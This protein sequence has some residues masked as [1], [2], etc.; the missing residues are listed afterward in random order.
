MAERKEN[1]NTRAAGSAGQSSAP[2]V[3]YEQKGGFIETR[4]TEG[5]RPYAHA[6]QAAANRP[7]TFGAMRR[8]VVRETLRNKSK[9]GA[10]ALFLL[11][12]F[13]ALCLSNAG[14]FKVIAG[15]A[16]ITAGAAQAGATLGL[17][18][19]ASRMARRTL[20]FG[21]LM[22]VA[23]AALL[24]GAPLTLGGGWQ[25]G[26]ALLIVL[27]RPL[28]KKINL[29]PSIFLGIAAAASSLVSLPL[30]TQSTASIL[31]C[32]GGAGAA[33]V[34]TPV[35]DRMNAALE[36]RAYLETDDRICV[37]LSVAAIVFG[38]GT[39]SVFGVNVGGALAL[40]TVM[41]AGFTAD[42]GS[43]VVTGLACAIALA[44][45]GFGQTGQTAAVAACALLFPLT[46]LL[47]SLVRGVN[48]LWT[49][50]IAFAANIIAG[51]LI[52]SGGVL[53]VYQSLAACLLF[54]AVPQSV[55]QS[56]AE[57]LERESITQTAP[58]GVAIQWIQSSA[59]ALSA[60]ARAVPD[61]EPDESMLIEQ[62]S[63][64]MCDKCERKE[65]CWNGRFDDTM[66]MM[67]DLVTASR[68]RV[69][70]EMELLRLA[71]A[72]GC[73]RYA[74]VASALNS[75][76][77]TA[78]R[79]NVWETAQSQTS[80]LAKLQLMG[81]ASLLHSISEMLTGAEA[82][83][84]SLRLRISRA[85]QKTRWS[86]CTAMPYMLNGLLQIV[87]I[88]PP[89][90]RDLGEPP[91]AALRR[92]LSMELT[93]EP[94]WDGLVYISEDPPYT[95]S[96][97]QAS[98]PAHGQSANGDGVRSARLPRARQLIALSD[99]MGHGEAAQ[100][101]SATVLKL[102]ENGFNAG[103]GRHELLAV[104]NDLVRACHGQE[105]YATVDL[106]VLDMRTGEAAFEKMGACSSFLIRH[107]AGKM[108]L[109]CRKLTGGTLP[110][111][112]LEDVSP[113]SF[114]MNL[115]TQDLLVMVSDGLI[116]AFGN[117]EAML[118]AMTGLTQDAQ[119]FCDGLMGMA[120]MRVSGK[121]KDDMTVVAARI[122]PRA[123]ADDAVVA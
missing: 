69:L 83:P 92:V 22:G 73:A 40:L 12:A 55:A 63:A 16:G 18:Y 34:M 2:T 85:L 87:L 6:T 120:F 53:S 66:A 46:A 100:N 61:P 29:A 54:L 8:N 62:L 64:I 48:K 20:P 37:L 65:N 71:K 99:G 122:K 121:P 36:Q 25:L 56:A 59:N 84:P 103:Y 82:A 50:A 90:M 38:A 115:S 75:I 79:Q 28:L 10:A 49:V 57:S 27:S 80:H 113:K 33:F 118:Q 112:I 101:E 117:E 41:L 86:A 5:G 78:R 35:F 98:V 30:M 9:L 1:T 45:S 96:I 89:D 111:G 67:S 7:Q 81:Q 4:A 110:M 91:I 13:V 104:V 108:G 109:K 68:E 76:D 107:E 74:Q 43:S 95:V 3:A 24:R 102:L 123:F 114:R 39:L 11:D 97:G 17:A 44:L 88:P 42:A 32:L 77:R 70:D 58:S 21:A 19:L 116:D 60:M 106:C 47:A 51:L 23:A 105:R 14:I 119:N 93:I 15:Q 72:G 31:I 26:A 94:L 52:G